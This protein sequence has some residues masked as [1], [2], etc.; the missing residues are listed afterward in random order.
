MSTPTVSA[1]TQV[2][3]PSVRAS[4]EARSPTW[5][6]GPLL[7]PRP[8]DT[9]GEAVSSVLKGYVG[10]VCV[11]CDQAHRHEMTLVSDSYTPRSLQT[12]G[13]VSHGVGGTQGGRG[14]VGQASQGERAHVGEPFHWGFRGRDRGSRT[15]SLGIGH[16][17]AGTCLGTGAQPNSVP[18]CASPEVAMAGRA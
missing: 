1:Q 17:S 3:S 4:E 2:A 10:A 18:E 16:C 5:G 12:G 11:R 6:Q 8:Q 13:T 9:R 7:R 14:Q 15:S